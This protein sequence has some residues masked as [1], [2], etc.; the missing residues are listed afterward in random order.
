MPA[1]VHEGGAATQVAISWGLVVGPA[2]RDAL[3]TRVEAASDPFLMALDAWVDAISG[4]VYLPNDRV[5]AGRAVL[6]VPGMVTLQREL[7]ALAYH[8]DLQIL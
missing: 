5:E 8:S 6:L 1:F 7:Q 2:E 3:F 4:A